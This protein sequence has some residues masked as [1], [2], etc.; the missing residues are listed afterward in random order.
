M[1]AIRT[2]Y[3]GILFRSKLEAQ[4][5]KF[6]DSIGMTWIY[7]P[8]GF[9]FED[10]TKYLPDFYLPDSKQWFEV[11]G[12]MNDLD[13][14][15]IKMLCKESGHDVVIGYPDGEFEMIDRYFSMDTALANDPNFKPSEWDTFEDFTHY[16]KQSTYINRCQKCGKL[17]FMNST[18]SYHCQCCG[19]YDGDHYIYWIMIGDKAYSKWEEITTRD[20]LARATIDIRGGE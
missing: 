10:G 1:E 14:H 12:V 15:K 17:S 3:K 7:E 18:G 16:D 19:A 13:M 8:E 9:A 4:W 5:A 20:W 2:R 11:K 6:F